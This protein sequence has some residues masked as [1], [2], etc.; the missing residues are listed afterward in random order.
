MSEQKILAIVVDRAH[1]E[2]AREAAR[3]LEEAIPKRNARG[4]SIGV[5]LFEGLKDTQVGLFMLADDNSRILTAAPLVY[6]CEDIA[7]LCNTISA[8]SAHLC[9]EGRWM[10]FVDDALRAR[11]NEI[12]MPPDPNVLRDEIRALCH[13]RRH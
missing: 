5:R 10:M 8:H 6:V 1:I 11:V 7:A 3:M 9:G 13:G 12:L 2:D 4:W